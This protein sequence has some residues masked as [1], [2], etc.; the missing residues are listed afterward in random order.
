MIKPVCAEKSCSGII[1]LF[2]VDTGVKERIS[3]ERLISSQNQKH[4]CLW[5]R[6]FSDCFIK[7]IKIFR[8]T[9]HHWMSPPCSR[10]TCIY[11]TPIPL[12]HLSL[13]AAKLLKFGD[14]ILRNHVSC[15]S[16]APFQFLYLICIYFKISIFILIKIFF[17]HSKINIE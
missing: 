5:L 1:P 7:S 14:I 2:T 17:F 13:I 11:L 15:S 6:T 16:T 4:A 10:K 12:K 9:S 8:V 3:G